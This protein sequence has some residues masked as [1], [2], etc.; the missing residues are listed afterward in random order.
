MKKKHLGSS[1]DE[2]LK[3]EGILE[4]AESAADEKMKELLEFLKKKRRKLNCV[5][6]DKC[7]INFQQ[8]S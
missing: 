1:F 6:A 5:G 7:Q 8:E 3:E 2:F 4:E